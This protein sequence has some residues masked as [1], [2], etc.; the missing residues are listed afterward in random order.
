MKK[1]FIILTLSAFNANGQLL[2]KEAVKDT[3][4]WQASKM[5]TVPKLV[6]FGE[7]DSESYTMYYRN[8]K[9]TTIT[10]IDYITTGD[11][12]TTKEFFELCNK[13]ISEDKEYNVVLNNESVSVQKMM[14]AVMIYKSNSYF[15]LNKKQVEVI[16]EKL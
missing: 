13:V 3:V 10:D 5:V 8:A 9:Y 2:V 7:G 15:Y 12:A 1:L 4:V 11:R 16:L 14:S 6:R